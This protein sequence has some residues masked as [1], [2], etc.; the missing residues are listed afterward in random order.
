[1]I[2][3]SAWWA[4]Y[5]IAFVIV[6]NVMLMNVVTGVICEQ[7]MEL[8]RKKIPDHQKTLDQLDLWKLKVWELFCEYD[9]DGSSALDT[10]ECVSLL[11][12]VRMREVLLEM[13]VGLPLEREHIICV[14]DEGGKGTLSFHDLF[15]GILRQQGTKSDI[16]S[17]SLQY[18]LARHDQQKSAS[19]DGIELA[20]AES[21]HG[22][23]RRAA[24]RLRE[25]AGAASAGA[26]GALPA[27]PAGA[28]LGSQWRRSVLAC[29]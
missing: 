2:A 22:S 1:M 26:R 16:L 25:R 12:S 17:Q 19:I 15:S 10:G 18:G 24:C 14:L 6:T 27:A 8:A 9:A 11:R 7:V 21:M 28:A 5:V 20:V 4:L 29:P 23:A 3:E 13:G